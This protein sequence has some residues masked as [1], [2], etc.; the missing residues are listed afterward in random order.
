MPRNDP[1]LAR[2]ARE[3]GAD[4]VKVYL[5]IND[6]HLGTQAEERTRWQTIDAA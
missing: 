3:G 1:D 5:D 4:V 6:T 2:A